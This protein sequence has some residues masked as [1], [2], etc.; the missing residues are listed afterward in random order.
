M[1]AFFL[2]WALFSP[3][4]AGGGPLTE[5]RAGL[6][7]R[8]RCRSRSAPKLVEVAG[9]AETYTALAITLGVLV[10]YGR[11][12]PRASR[13]QRRALMAVAVTSLLFLP[14]YFVVQLRRLGPVSST[15]RR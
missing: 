11:R 6:P 10:V 9:K 15:R 7:A 13:P 4:I 5:L 2:P 14:A 12:L 1:L 3:V 8:T